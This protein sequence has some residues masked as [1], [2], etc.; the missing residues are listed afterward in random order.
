M[1]TTINLE[2][3]D[4]REFMSMTPKRKAAIE[5]ASTE[6]IP[7]EYPVNATAKS[8]HPTKQYVKIEVIEEHR[9][10]KSYLLVPRA[11][12]GTEHLAYF[13]AGQYV[14]VHL[15]INGVTT[16]KPYSIRSCP[17]EALEDRYILTVKH[18]EDGFASE[19][20]LNNWKLGDTVCLTGPQGQFT[21]EG[22]R[23]APHV[24]GLAGGSGITPFYSLACAIAEGKEDCTLTLLYGSKTL[25]DILFKKEFDELTE[26]CSALKVVHVLSEAVAQ[27]H[28][29][30]FITAELIK[31][32]APESDYS[33]FVC[34]P[35][36]MYNFVDK[37]IEKLGLP[38]NRVR[39]ELFGEFK[40][41]EQ[42]AD[43]P[44]DKGGH[45][46]TVTVDVRD[47]KQE[48]S[49]PADMTLLNAM[50]QAGIAAPALCRSGECGFCHSRLV[51]GEVY[52]PASVDGRRL[53]DFTYGYIHPCCS[54]PL[55]DVEI[56]V[57]VE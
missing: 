8:L 47:T 19:Y 52:V 51:A 34:G 54:F 2:A 15:N 10:A 21:Y 49:C 28:E 43:Y 5:A 20:I 56:D 12:L 26:R 46:Y 7:A 11:D 24:V 38:L 37:E 44:Q 41:P 22:L 36:A 27:G 9:D 13:S 50:E 1:T 3:L 14:G 18:A 55:S 35:Q 16:T 25:E 57:P 6:P 39:H 48:I 30:G 4:P 32:Y 45:V 17:S 33:L 31:K 53:A 40:H 29:Q 42:E 23:D